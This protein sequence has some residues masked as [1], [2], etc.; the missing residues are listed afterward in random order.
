VRQAKFPLPK[1]TDWKGLRVKGEIE[2]KGQRYPLYWACRQ[3]LNP[4]GS[5]TLAPTPGID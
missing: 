1:G 5:L 3:S 4:D 2:V